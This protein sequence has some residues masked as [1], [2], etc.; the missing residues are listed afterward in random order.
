M[1][2][3]AVN[4]LER[5]DLEVLRTWKVRG[6]ILCES[7]KGLFILKEFSGRGEKLLLQDAFLTFLKQQGFLQAEELLKNKDGELLSRD[8]DGT[9]YIVKTYSE[10]RECST[11]SG[12]EALLDGCAAMRTLARVHKISGSFEGIAGMDKK[13]TGLTLQEFEKHNR[14]LKKVRRF[15]K[16]KGQKSD[17]EHFL[18]QNY[19]LFLDQALAVS[20]QLKEEKAEDGSAVLCHGDF[21]YHNVLFCESGV[22]LMNFEKC[23]WDDRSRDIYHFS[24]K[25]L[26]KSNWSPETGEALLGAYEKELAL[27]PEEMRQL[28]YRFSYPEK[29]WKV[30]NYYYNRGKAFIPDKNREKL[31]VLLEQEER[32]G[33]F[34]KNV[35]GRRFGERTQENM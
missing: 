11:G 12:R 19:D 2:P 33:T 9:G 15:L 20:K 25:M 10:G 17:F 34:I 7:D 24:R 30:V 23:I 4:V 35:I 29:F 27:E 26:E 5:Y 13:R 8:A 22:R 6:A 14:E 18:Q 1:K 31:E 16:E 28:Y 32:R 21:Q 3:K